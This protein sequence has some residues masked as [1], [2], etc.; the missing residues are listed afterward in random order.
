MYTWSPMHTLGGG[1]VCQ[2]LYFLFD[3]ALR[4]AFSLARSRKLRRCVR[5]P[6]LN[7]LAEINPVT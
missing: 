1:F 6:T 5:R 3:S 4:F 7:C 2:S